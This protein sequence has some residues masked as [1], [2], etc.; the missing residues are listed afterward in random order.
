M[1]GDGGRERKGAGGKRE[2][3][4]ESEIENREEKMRFKGKRRD[5]N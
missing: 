5:R 1:Q 3:E 4:R 2:A